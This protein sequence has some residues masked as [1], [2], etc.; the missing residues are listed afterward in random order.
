VKRNATGPALLLPREEGAHVARVFIQV[1]HALPVALGA[2]E[3]G[4]VQPEVGL[5][6]AGL[7]G[8]RERRPDVAV[9]LGEQLGARARRARGLAE[10]GR[11]CRQARDCKEPRKHGSTEEK[12]VE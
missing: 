11:R 6:V 4:A 8:L 5:D 3:V 12:Q 2:H 1:R 10:R 9:D 7:V